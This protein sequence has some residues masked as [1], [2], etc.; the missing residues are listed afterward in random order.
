MLFSK[1]DILKYFRLAST[2]IAI[3]LVILLVAFYLVSKLEASERYEIKASKNILEAS[4]LIAQTQIGLVE[5]PGNKGGHVEDYLAS[6]N[7][8][9]PAPYCMAGQYWCYFIAS[10]LNGEEIPIKKTAGAVAQFNYFKANGKKTEFIPKRHDFLVWKTQGSWTGHIERI[11]EVLEGGWVR[12]IGFNTGADV[13]D[14]G[15][16]IERLRHIKNP[17][18]RLLVRGIAGFNAE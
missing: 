4:E 12:T 6:V 18:S 5:I 9:K 17:L 7:I 15:K 10:K 2:Y 1:E 13:R 14:G 8:N 11:T 3:W 16:V